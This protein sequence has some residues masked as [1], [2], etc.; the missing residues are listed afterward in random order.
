[1]YDGNGNGTID[2]EDFLG[3]LGLFGDVD[4]DSD[5]LWDSQDGCFDINGCNYLELDAEFCIYPDAVGNCNGNCPQDADG[6]GICDLY[7]CGDP[8]T[9]YGYEYE[10]VFIGG[11]CWFN[12]NLR[13]S[14]YLNGDSIQAGISN[15]F[16]STTGK[17]C[18]YGDES[19]SSCHPSSWGGFDACNSS[20]SIQF[21]GKLYNWFAVDDGRG[22]CPA[23]W[24]VST[25]EDWVGVEIS[26]GMG[27]EEAFLD[28][29]RGMADSVG[30]KLK[31]ESGW[32]NDGNGSNL[33]EF[34]AVPGGYRISTAF[35][36]AGKEAIFWTSAQ[37]NATE[38]WERF[39]RYE[40]YATGVNRQ[41]YSKTVGMSVRC[42]QNPE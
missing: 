12:E 15:W 23:G 26:L 36:S 18:V 29:W 37:K 41:S 27:E 5:G 8:V 3:I 21:Y 1:M 13:T 22:L 2:I 9:F 7:S 11:N 4:V 10:T 19:A 17:S 6:D 31:S 30:Y 40:S 35:Y 38:A 39:L 42:V 25:D 24:H 14:R 32:W 28:G 16:D 20:E 33:S 34:G